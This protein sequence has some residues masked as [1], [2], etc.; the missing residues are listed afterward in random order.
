MSVEKLKSRAREV[1]LLAI[2]TFAIGF[3][4]LQMASRPASV[5]CAS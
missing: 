3:G 1:M 2:A 5:A 4:I